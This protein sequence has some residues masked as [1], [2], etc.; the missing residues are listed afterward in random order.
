MADNLRA[1]LDAH[2]RLLEVERELHAWLD[3][4]I[5]AEPA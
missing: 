2:R 5:T 4:M 1:V 3:Q